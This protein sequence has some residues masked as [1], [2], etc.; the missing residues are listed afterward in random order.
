MK[1]VLNK[2]HPLKNFSIYYRSK[3][4]N[5]TL[6]VNIFTQKLTLRALVINSVDKIKRT[7]PTNSARDR[8]RTGWTKFVPR[9]F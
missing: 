9:D 6:K 2:V 1:N 4:I 3:R 5:G 7:G 8:S